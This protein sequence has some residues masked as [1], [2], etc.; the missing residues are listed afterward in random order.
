MKKAKNV[1]VYYATCFTDNI[2]YQRLLQETWLL[3]AFV[4]LKTLVLFF[5][6]FPAFCELQCLFYKNNFVLTVAMEIFYFVLAYSG[7]K[8]IKL[9]RC[10]F[11]LP[12]SDKSAM[13]NKPPMQLHL[14]FH[15]T[16]NR[17]NLKVWIFH[18]HKP[19]S[20]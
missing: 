7:L 1:F 4:R 6:W 14:D 12:T 16:V 15:K 19:S 13:Q 2:R 20:F 8:I 11:F 3:L 17:N 10:F 5:L 18:I 9:K